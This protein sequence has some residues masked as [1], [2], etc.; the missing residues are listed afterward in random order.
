MFIH[1]ITNFCIDDRCDSSH[2]PIKVD[3]NTY[4]SI[5]QD[6]FNTQNSVQNCQVGYIIPQNRKCEFVTETN[7]IFNETANVELIRKI[8]NININ[9]NEIMDIFN[10]KLKE[11]GQNFLKKTTNSTRKV[12]KSPWFDQEC[13]KSKLQKYKALKQFRKNKIDANLNNY[14][15]AKKSFKKLCMEKQSAY[16]LSK[17]DSISQCI[18]NPKAFWSKVKKMLNKND[19]TVNNITTEEWLDHFQKL[20]N[21]ENNN[22]INENTNANNFLDNEIEVEGE[23]EDYIFNG[24]IEEDEIRLAVKHLKNG[25]KPGPDNILPEFFTYGLDYFVDIM[26]K[27]FNRLYVNGEYPKEWSESIIVTLH[28]KGNIN[29]TNNYR[30]ISLQNV[31]SKVYCRVLVNRLNFYVELYEKISENQTGF[32]A[33]YSTVDNAFILNSVISHVFNRNK[34]NGKLYVAFIDFKKCFDTIDRPTMW[35]ILLKN[36]VKGNLFKAI[37]SMYNSVKACIKCNNGRSDYI[38]ST[39]GLKQGCL[40]SP[41]LFSLFIDEFETI[42]CQSDIRGIQLHPDT[43]Q[44]LLLM[45][46]DD[47]A[48]LSDTVNGLQKQLNMLSDF[49]DTYKLTV[50]EQKSKIIVF[51]KGGK[52][53]RKENWTYKN[54]KL[55]VV[56]KFSYVGLTYTRQMSLNAMVHDLL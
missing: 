53:A 3:L 22:R 36:G 20:L 45:F 48:L 35:N 32:K 41:I 38:E 54:N 19:S 31:L 7:K 33:G 51:K 56:N 17:I 15:D 40:A 21:P 13:R 55:E 16:N 39:I 49:C 14:I 25:K 28:K 26:V 5:R 18:N 2:L 10:M 11:V 27:L 47:L 24:Y 50:N 34:G 30:G 6:A 4:Q 9:I 37:H 52:L 8:E 29:D 46:A 43:I 23:I 12:S 1:R 44:L 42:L